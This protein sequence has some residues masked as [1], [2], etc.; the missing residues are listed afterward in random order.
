[1]A[2][3]ALGFNNPGYQAYAASAQGNYSGLASAG[4]TGQ[5]AGA[6]LG[7]EGEGK[8]G[9]AQEQIGMTR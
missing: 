3:A 4:V 8:V 9:A 1:M 6:S 5:M 7:I 2:L